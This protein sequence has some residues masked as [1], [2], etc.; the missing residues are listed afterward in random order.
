MCF[1]SCLMAGF[2][3]SDVEPSVSAASE[4]LNVDLK[5]I[6][7]GYEMLHTCLYSHR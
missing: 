6:L 4:S 5:E 1:R 2:D 3:F 7:A